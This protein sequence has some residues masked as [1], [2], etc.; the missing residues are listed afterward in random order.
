[1][2]STL[3]SITITLI[4]VLACLF[5]GLILMEFLLRRWPI[6]NLNLFAKLASGF[7]L[8]QGILASVWLLVGLGSVFS[9]SIIWLI[10]IVILIFGFFFLRHSYQNVSK[11][12]KEGIEKLKHLSLIW[13][14]ILLMVVALILS[15]GVWSFL[16][17]PAGDAEAFYMVLP[18]IMASSE[19]LQ[20]QPNYYD[21]SQ[22]GLVG[23]M[24]FAALISITDSAAAQFFTWF[25][26]LAAMMFLLLIGSMLK[27]K[28]PGQI[29]A[30]VMLF[31]TSTFTL[32]ISGGKVDIFGAAFGLATYFWLL[33][34]YENKEV[35]GPAFMLTG[36]FMGFA[37]VAKFPNLIVI[38]PG[39]LFIIAWN[40]YLR[41]QR[42]VKLFCHNI[43]V[44]VVLV[45]LFFII[46]CLPHLIKNWILFGEPLAPFIFIKQAGTKWAEQSWFSRENIHYI[47]KT[48]PIAL[49]YGQYP[50]QGG[51]MSFLLLAF[52]SLIIFSGTLKT[53][54]KGKFFQ[55]LG[56][57]L[58]GLLSWVFLRPGVMAPRYILATLLLAIPLVAKIVD[59]IFLKRGFLILKIIII[60]SLV[61]ILSISLY[62]N[63]S[64]IRQF[65]IMGKANFQ[66]YG[67]FSARSSEFVNQRVVKGDR[68][69]MAGYYTYFLR[70]DILQCLSTQFERD[71][72]ALKKESPEVWTYLYN[73][74]FK[75]IVIQKISFPDILNSWD[76]NKKPDWLEIKEIY[77]DPNIII[78][79]LGSNKPDEIPHCSCISNAKAWDAHCLSG[80]KK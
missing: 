61:L 42:K 66:K 18:K 29:V 37:V 74:D 75:Y 9:K 40:S 21:F 30:I 20:P 70:P 36:L 25:T 50:M 78:Y 34:A 52:T 16:N 62:S 59:D 80:V 46:A 65:L 22:I 1:M 12:I 63:Y 58:I 60:S 73:Q 57:I 67:R 13:K 8:G 6:A 39:I 48:Y 76:I 32:Y 17:L 11:K 55:L 5:L 7:M 68:V 3:T 38:I 15:Y 41:S 44:P 35:D 28:V 54:V 23:E 79:S 14:I 24:H 53:A 51:N 72:Q 77:S 71:D 10:I 19:R 45:G 33:L 31:T 69:F 49:T 4:Y 27:L 43:V 56:V 2:I 47:L 64:Q 26:A